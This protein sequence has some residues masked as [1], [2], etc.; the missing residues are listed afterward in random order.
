MFGQPPPAN[1]LFPHPKSFLAF[2]SDPHAGKIKSSSSRCVGSLFIAMLFFILNVDPSNLISAVFILDPHDKLQKHRFDNCRIFYSSWKSNF[3]H[4]LLLWIEQPSSQYFLSSNLRTFG[5]CHFSETFCCKTC[6]D[7]FWWPTFLT[8]MPFI[9]Q[10]TF[11]LLPCITSPLMHTQQCLC[12]TMEFDNYQ[13]I[14][15]V[16]LLYCYT[17]LMKN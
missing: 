8:R 7:L 2:Q 5:D 10:S 3:T 14:V 1:P 12:N 16:F 11:L 9:P 4:T 13:N 6:W 17:R 15:I